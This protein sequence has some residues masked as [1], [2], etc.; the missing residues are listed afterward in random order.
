MVEAVPDEL[1]SEDALRRC[2]LQRQRQHHRDELLGQ[3][4]HALG[5]RDH[6]LVEHVDCV[7]LQNQVL[8]LH[9]VERLLLHVRLVAGKLKKLV[10]ILQV[11]N[12]A[13]HVRNQKVA[14]LI[15]QVR[16][17]RHLVHHVQRVDRKQLRHLHLVQQ[18]QHFARVDVVI[19]HVARSRGLMNCLD[20]YVQIRDVVHELLA[21]THTASRV[22][23]AGNRTHH[24]Q[25]RR[26]HR[27]PHDSLSLLV[28]AALLV[29]VRFHV[30][31]LDGDLIRR[32]L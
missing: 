31:L 23:S 28:L 13:L 6:Q 1:R 7:L 20:Q 15:R 12:H 17:R 30:L 29:V 8:K 26:T 19:D 3:K 32:A 25:H 16:W 4:T 27:V 9:N 21:H 22:Q 2:R 18:H 24:L 11:D 14:R 5:E 10:W